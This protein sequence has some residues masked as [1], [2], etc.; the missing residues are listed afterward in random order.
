MSISRCSHSQILG[1]RNVAIGSHFIKEYEFSWEGGDRYSQ[2]KNAITRL[3]RQ[4]K[5]SGRNRVESDSCLSDELLKNYI[6]R[7]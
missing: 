5:K 4:I 6:H 3:L 7:I 1:G 2:V